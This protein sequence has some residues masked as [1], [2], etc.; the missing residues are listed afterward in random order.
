MTFFKKYFCN[1]CHFLLFLYILFLER[2]KLKYV[3][4]YV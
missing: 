2:R 1:I 3:K 4:N